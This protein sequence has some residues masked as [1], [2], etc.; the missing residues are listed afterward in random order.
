MLYLFATNA[1]FY[2]INFLLLYN[3]ET[4]N[5]KFVGKI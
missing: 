4:I 2:Q 1:I 5:F 3:V